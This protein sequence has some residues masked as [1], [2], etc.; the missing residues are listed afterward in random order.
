MCVFCVQIGPK[1]QKIF[2]EEEKIEQ[3]RQ[4]H[5]EIVA[6]ARENR[7]CRTYEPNPSPNYLIDHSY[8]ELEINDIVNKYID[9]LPLEV[10][11]SRGIYGMEERYSLSMSDKCII[12]Y[13]KKRDLVR[14]QDP[15]TNN[16][17]SIP[18]RSAIKFALV[19]NP[20]NDEEQA[21][22]GL[23]FPFVSDILAMNDLP[24]MGLAQLMDPNIEGLKSAELIVIKEVSFFTYI[25]T[26]L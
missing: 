11:V 9:H 6:A 17:F 21:R 7:S 2:T 26:D 16:E 13:V 4:K 3:R 22:G 8:G 5:K 10:V 14:I 23:N 20:N 25:I 12:H 19:Y 18:L 24:K 15:Q 1:P